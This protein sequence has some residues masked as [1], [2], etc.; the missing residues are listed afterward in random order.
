MGK[1]FEGKRNVESPEVIFHD[2]TFEQ[3]DGLTEEV[4]LFLLINF[5]TN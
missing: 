4:R 2:I 5:S 3:N 1:E